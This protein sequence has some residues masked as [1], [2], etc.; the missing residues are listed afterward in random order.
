MERRRYRAVHRTTY[1]YGAEVVDGYSVAHLVARSTPA[2]EVIASTVTTEPE[3]DEFALD[4]SAPGYR[5]LTLRADGRIDSS[6][7]RIEDPDPE[8]EYGGRSY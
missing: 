7:H 6:V 4:T 2:Q 3:A 1:E 8:P 5:S